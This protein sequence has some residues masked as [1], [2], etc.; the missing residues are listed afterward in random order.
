MD[1]LPPPEDT[2]SDADFFHLENPQV[3]VE[4]RSLALGLVD[5]GHSFYSIKGLFE[6]LRFKH[7]IKTTGKPYKIN[8]NLT[9]FYARLLMAN[10]PRLVG[11]FK[12]RSRK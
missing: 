8:N 4:L 7:A 3:Y 2:F 6:V 1:I 10:E 9:P 5:A 11:F 12:I